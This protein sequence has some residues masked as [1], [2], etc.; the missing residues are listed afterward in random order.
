MDSE[1]KEYLDIKFEGVRAKLQA[2]CDITDMI[3]KQIEKQNGRI[4]TTERETSL[5]RII[6][7]NPTPSTAVLILLVFGIMFAIQN[8][9]F[10]FLKIG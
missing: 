6:Q 1:I 3:Y 8:G 9:W 5:W 2:N 4:T 10:E 7:R